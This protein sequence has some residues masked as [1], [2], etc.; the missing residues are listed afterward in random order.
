MLITELRDKTLELL[1]NRPVWLT[2]A[3]IAEDTTIP[4]GWLK[5]FA[6]GKIADPS[7]NRIETLKL[8]LEAKGK[9]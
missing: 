6:Q 4:H 5:V 2:L 9:V 8:Y 7:V 3:I 1:K